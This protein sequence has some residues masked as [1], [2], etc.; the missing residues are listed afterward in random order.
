MVINNEP[1]LT[2]K[3]NNIMGYCNRNE[4]DSACL[5][6]R[7]MSKCSLEVMR[8][9]VDKVNDYDRII[10]QATQAYVTLTKLIDTTTDYIKDM[11]ETDNETT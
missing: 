2:V 7:G 8:D 3:L 1:I 9:L 10:Q 6:Y 4:C 11:E 5:L